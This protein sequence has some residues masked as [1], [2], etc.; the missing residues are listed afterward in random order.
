MLRRTT[1]STRTD[2]LCPYTTLFRSPSQ[3][4]VGQITPQATFPIGQDASL[5]E[6]RVARDRIGD[7][8]NAEMQRERQAVIRLAQG[9]RI[10][11]DRDHRD[12]VLRD[13]ACRTLQVPFDVVRREGAAPDGLPIG[14]L[15][16]D[17]KS[18]RLNSSN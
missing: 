17:R 7:D 2:T 10:S 18:T 13:D 4:F 3:R 1:R 11:H 15:A 5:G 9:D 6:S 12:V 14:A 16:V 8:R